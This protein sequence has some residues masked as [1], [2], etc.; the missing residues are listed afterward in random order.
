MFCVGADQVV[1]G[2]AAGRL[3][4]RML[5]GGRVISYGYDDDGNVTSITPP[6]RPAHRLSSNAAGLPEFYA[7]PDVGD[8][9][10]ATQVHYNLDKQVTSM[11]RPDGST[12]SYRYDSGGRLSSLTSADATIDYTYNDATGQLTSIDAPS[13]EQLTFGY[14]G[15]LSTTDT[16][17]GTVSGSV[18]RTFNDDMRVSRVTVAGADPV[19]Y[20][21]DEDDHDWVQFPSVGSP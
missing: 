6:G 19:T 21:Y 4:E 17:S 16:L 15:G 10:R 2:D 9:A 8:G 11:D 1:A 14:D 12:L 5:P 7:A 20:A 3:L 18:S 13:G